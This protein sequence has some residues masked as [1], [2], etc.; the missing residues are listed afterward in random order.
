M[1]SETWLTQDNIDQCNFK[2][3]HPIHLIRPSNENIGFKSKG[4]GV[5]IFVRDHLTFRPR[6]DLSI[7][8]PFMECS[9]IEI[10][11]N[12]IKYLIGG[13]YRM[14]DTDINLFTEHFNNVIEP[15]NSTHKLILLGDYNVDLLKDD[16]D[17]NNLEICMQSNY[18][19]PTIHAPTRVSLCITQNGEERLS[20]T[21]RDNIFID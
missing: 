20:S 19:M 18:L 2:G 4:G 10:Q 5:S 14:P 8:Q 12:S 7:M 6:N 16:S 17:R 13:I 1:F 21:L 15:L 9:F 3:F 11:Y